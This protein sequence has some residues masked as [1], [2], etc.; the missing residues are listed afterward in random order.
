MC[1][2][3]SEDAAIGAAEKVSTSH[4]LL[5]HAIPSSIGLQFNRLPD[6]DGSRRLQL[7]DTPLDETPS[8][9]FNFTLSHFIRQRPAL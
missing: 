9:R 1:E 7:I 2:A 6:C 3:V 4:L 8:H 5:E